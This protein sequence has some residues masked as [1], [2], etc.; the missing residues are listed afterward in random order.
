MMMNEPQEEG[1]FTDNPWTRLGT[2]F[3]PKS[4]NT[5]IYIIKCQL[6]QP[7]NTEI[8]AYK[9]SSSNLHKHIEVSCTGEM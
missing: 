8:S 5:S 6:C 1:A 2:A 7:K 9:N 3:V 4:K